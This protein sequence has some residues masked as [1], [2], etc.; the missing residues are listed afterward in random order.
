MCLVIVHSFLCVAYVHDCSRMSF[1]EVI[2][3][4]MNPHWEIRPLFSCYLKVKAK[5][6]GAAFFLR[7]GHWSRPVE[8]LP[9]T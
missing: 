2:L 1:V 8:V 4:S 7:P 3:F 5:P 9:L 6:G